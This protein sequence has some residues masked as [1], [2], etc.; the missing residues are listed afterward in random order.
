M[1]RS[2]IGDIP[3]TAEHP[4]PEGLELRPALPEHYRKIWD[5]DIEASKDGW[6]MVEHPDER[7][8]YFIG[9]LEFQPEK[10]QIAWDIETDEVA[11]AVMPFI[12]EEENKAFNRLRGYT[13][14]IHVSRN[15]RGK[16]VA[17]SLIASAFG[18]LKEL[19]MEETALGVDA[20]N[21]TG[22]LNLYKAMG[23]EEDKTFFTFRK[24]L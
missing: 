17:K 7:Y 3:T 18:L 16:G 19:G 13:E 8:N 6:E 4:L 20:E 21:P 24:K 14:F 22:A 11:G 1:M 10:M 9:K 2:L 5:A 12:N 15:W 23:F